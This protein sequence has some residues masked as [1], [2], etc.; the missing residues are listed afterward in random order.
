MVGNPDVYRK[1]VTMWDLITH[2]F[3]GN[4]MLNRREHGWTHHSWRPVVVASFRMDHLRGDGGVRAF[5]ITNVI[6]H[7]FSALV[8]YGCYRL[9]FPSPAR[10]RALL[11]G[12]LFALHPIH[13]ECVANITSRADAVA[14]L[15]QLACI[16][17]YVAASGRIVPALSAAARRA[18]TSSTSETGGDSAGSAAESGVRRRAAALCGWLCR[19]AMWGRDNSGTAPLEEDRR[20]GCCSATRTALRLAGV[21]LLF[22][23]L[24]LLS[25]AC[26]ETSLMV[27]FLAIVHDI[28]L[29]MATAA[30][31]VAAADASLGAS[32]SSW[33]MTSEVSPG[34][35]A[36]AA[37]AAAAATAA[38]EARAFAASASRAAT[39]LLS[40]PGETTAVAGQEA[41]CSGSSVNSSGAADDRRASSSPQRTRPRPR[42]I[43]RA[44]GA[45]SPA[46]SPGDGEESLLHSQS[47]A[48][49]PQGEKERHVRFGTA[50]AGAGVV[51]AQRGRSAGRKGTA[52]VGSSSSNGSSSSSGGGA[53]EAASLASAGTQELEVELVGSPTAASPSA[54]AS[55]SAAI[56]TVSGE[57][58]LRQHAVAVS[59][60]KPAK[61]AP[62]E[63]R[64]ALVYVPVAPLPW[65]TATAQYLRNASLRDAPWCKAA[66]LFAFGFAVYYV[67]IIIVARGYT[68]STW[69]NPIH[70]SLYHTQDRVER[71]MS[72]A[73]VQAWAL[74]KL[75]LPIFLS[76]EH[77]AL[78]HVTSLADGRNLLTL[79]AWISLAGLAALSFSLLRRGCAAPRPQTTQQQEQ[80][81]QKQHD[82]VRLKAGYASGCASVVPASASVSTDGHQHKHHGSLPESSVSLLSSAYVLLFGLGWVAVSYFPSSHAVQY[83]AFVLAERTLYLPSFGAA[84][85]LAEVSALAFGARMPVCEQT[86]QAEQ[87]SHAE[88][89][90]EQQQQELLQGPPAAAADQSAFDDDGVPAAGSPASKAAQPKMRT[91]V[92]A[93]YRIRQPVSDSTTPSKRPVPAPAA[94]SASASPTAAASTTISTAGSSIAAEAEGGK[95]EHAAKRRQRRLRRGATVAATAALL[96]WYAVRTY[97]RNW[98]WID[99]EAL[100]RNNMEMYPSG[101][102]MTVYGLGAVALYKGNVDE[103]EALLVRACNE[104]TMVEPHILLSQLYWKYRVHQPAFAHNASNVAVWELQRVAATVTPRKEV[105]TNLGL[106][107]MRRVH[108]E[109]EPV[110]DGSP[111]AAAAI[112][113]R[114]ESLRQA[115]YYILAAHVAH[116]YPEG[117]SAIAQLA[118]NAACVRLM[119]TTNRYGEPAAAEGLI[120]EALA[121]ARNGG[122][123]GASFRNAATFY[124]VQGYPVHALDILAEGIGHVEESLASAQAAPPDAYHG[125]KATVVQ[126]F[127]DMLYGLQRQALA[128]SSHS[129]LIASWGTAGQLVAGKAAEPRMA[130]LGLECVHELLWW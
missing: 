68:L 109:P 82:A 3:W 25:L 2:D 40:L 41:S 92:V 20:S 74:S 59:R 7:V 39:P 42:S 65:R 64:G 23:L 78:Q 87:Q 93:G 14:S 83:V 113:E 67:R 125:N 91:V 32:S 85:V 107:Q 11:S 71:L 38:L 60:S 22:I 106:L 130:A 115:E 110:D 57:T 47:P 55:A 16:A 102:V 96:A 34:A 51:A 98:D 70:N 105:L 112:A 75:V 52:G 100:M 54:S 61:P 94:T 24:L 28:A 6:V 35:T 8:A 73:M 49:S 37:S 123:S 63:Q 121:I 81:Q 124:A 45:G 13:S 95:A 90:D 119:S 117:H 26:K 4:D 116:G 10:G 97:T 66:L 48:S 127:F 77:N 21:S 53:S 69:A 1:S 79:A 114:E 108:S 126:Y 58:K 19:A 89:Q 46:S 101:N 111:E 62:G 29:T 43:L 84:M 9:L 56:V 27:P 104:S 128:I 118:S 80:Q 86:E 129:A 103:A 99:E 36:K 76:H 44:P 72:I 88:H 18:L 50:G 12:V 30:V 33:A 17:L 31:G 5:H 122:G 120:N 15:V